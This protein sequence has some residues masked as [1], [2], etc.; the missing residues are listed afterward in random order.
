MTLSEFIVICKLKGYVRYHCWCGGERTKTQNQWRVIIGNGV[1][2][3]HIVYDDIPEGDKIVHS[4]W[5]LHPSDVTYKIDYHPELKEI[6]EN[7]LP[8]EV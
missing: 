8:G 2:R 1:Y 4:R 7:I 6:I 3:V 5:S